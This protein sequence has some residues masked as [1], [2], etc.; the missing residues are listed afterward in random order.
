MAPWDS[1]SEKALETAV[2]FELGRD[3]MAW[4]VMVEWIVD[5]VVAAVWRFSDERRRKTSNNYDS[6]TRNNVSK[7]G[8]CDFQSRTGSGLELEPV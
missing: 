8:S 3:D 2:F 5:S 6:S 1:T 7:T 4:L